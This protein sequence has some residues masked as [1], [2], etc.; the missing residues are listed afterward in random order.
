[1]AESRRG[2]AY[3]PIDLYSFSSP[4][5]IVD[6]HINGGEQTVEYS[7]SNGTLYSRTQIDAYRPSG[8]SHQTITHQYMASCGYRWDTG[9]GGKWVKS[10]QT[11]EPGQVINYN[12]AT[13][14]PD[15]V[16]QRTLSQ[17]IRNI[18]DNQRYTAT[19]LDIASG[20][21]LTPVSRQPQ[22]KGM[23]SS[24]LREFRQYLTDHRDLIF[25][26]VIVAAV[27]AFF[28]DGALKSRLKSILN[29]F[30]DKAEQKLQKDINGDGKIA[31]S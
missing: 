30:I 23:V 25:T 11:G 9:S 31:G 26:V 3:Q 28:L 10:S 1:M 5:R 18:V 4:V 20:D 22:S 17:G 7:L 27:D 12:P 15:Q 16:Y 21:S 13:E 24:M 8:M 6:V 29:G 19:R 14:T 2:A